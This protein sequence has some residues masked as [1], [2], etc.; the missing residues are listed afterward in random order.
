MFSWSNLYSGIVQLMCTMT[1]LENLFST[2]DNFL[3]QAPYQDPI[4]QQQQQQ[5][6]NLES[7]YWGGAIRQ[8]D[9]R[10]NCPPVSEL[11]N[12]QEVTLAKIATLEDDYSKMKRALLSSMDEEEE[13]G[14]V[15]EDV[16]AEFS[17][18]IASSSKLSHVNSSSSRSSSRSFN[19][20]PP[21]NRDSRQAAHGKALIVEQSVDLRG[22]PPELKHERDVLARASNVEGSEIRGRSLEKGRLLLKNLEHEEQQKHCHHHQQQHQLHASD[23]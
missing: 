4:Q 22:N 8:F 6:T 10:T 19:P 14:E 17:N 18:V 9:P 15:E 2:T 21:S 23:N 3:F 5:Q 12:E 13:E 20:E 16:R 1:T 11:V 7:E